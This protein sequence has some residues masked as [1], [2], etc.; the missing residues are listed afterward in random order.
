M[1]PEQK[2]EPLTRTYV[3]EWRQLRGMTL[4]TFAEQVGWSAPRIS[5]IEQGRAAYHQRVLE[6]FATVLECEPVDLLFMPGQK[7]GAISHEKAAAIRE[8]WAIA[9][10]LVE[11]A[12]DLMK[13]ASA[14]LEEVNT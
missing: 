11:R 2:E 4:A 6:R 1:T 7:P 8:K 12:R 10:Y 14:I 9:L 5:L 13:E 3:R